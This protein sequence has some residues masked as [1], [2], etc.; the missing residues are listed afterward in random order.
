MRKQRH[1]NKLLYLNNFTKMHKLLKLSKM[2][3]IQVQLIQLNKPL[4]QYLDL[5]VSMK[6]IIHHKQLS[7]NSKIKQFIKQHNHL[8]QV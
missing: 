7:K 3:W 4:K 8:R 6:V 5:R 1:L 2:S